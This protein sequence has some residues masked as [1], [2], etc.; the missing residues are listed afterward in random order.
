MADTDDDA[1][2]AALA[3]LRC[4]AALL[5]S[6]P[7]SSCRLRSGDRVLLEVMRP[8]LAK[9]DHPVAP[10]CW[11]RAQVAAA[12]RHHPAHP[13]A[14]AGP[15]WGKASLADLAVD[16]G[17]SAGAAVLPMSVIRV[18]YDDA[19]V[20]L[21]AVAQ[22]LD[23]VRPIAEELADEEATECLELLWD[24]ELDA[25]VLALASPRDDAEAGDA[26]ADVL[27]TVGMQTAI[28][29]LEALLAETPAI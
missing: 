20:H 14:A 15:L 16:I 2:H 21:L 19:W 17:V 11:F 13:H 1:H 7:A 9:R 6:T 29:G 28:C 3:R 25:T 18:P 24:R 4:A 23:V 12:T 5:A 26:A 8:P 27:R 10:A 22:P